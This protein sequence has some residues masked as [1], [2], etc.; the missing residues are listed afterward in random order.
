[1]RAMLKLKFILFICT[2][3]IVCG[4]ANLQPKP[5]GD[6][7]PFSAQGWGGT[8]CNEMLHDIHPNTAG[9][10]AAQ[11]IGLYQSWISGFVSGVNYT[12]DDAY[13]VSGATSPEESFEWVKNYCLQYPIDPLPVALHKLIQHWNEQG[14]LLTEPEPSN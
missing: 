11:N 14:K 2:T 4:C 3:A 8:T 7:S 12:R 5:S 13:D 9:K 6:V 1:M 10:Q